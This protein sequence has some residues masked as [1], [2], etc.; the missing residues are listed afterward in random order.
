M[1]A[2][3]AMVGRDYRLLDENS[4]LQFPAGQFSA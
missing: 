3:S 2:R 4:E 1:R